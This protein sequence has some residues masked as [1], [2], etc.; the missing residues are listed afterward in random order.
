MFLSKISLAHISLVVFSDLWTYLCLW[1]FPAVCL[2]HIHEY[3]CQRQNAVN[4]VL[5]SSGMWK[6]GRSKRISN[7]KDG[8][9]DTVLV[10]SVL[11][12]IWID[13]LL[14]VVLGFYILV[15]ST[16]LCSIC[17][18]V[19]SLCLGQCLGSLSCSNHKWQEITSWRM[20]EISSSHNTPKSIRFTSV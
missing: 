15:G 18:T 7:V 2:S 20:V 14:A 13:A 8:N 9:K 16:L 11:V 4:L 19:L 3:V 5:F 6:V 12:F 10:I 17:C 1:L